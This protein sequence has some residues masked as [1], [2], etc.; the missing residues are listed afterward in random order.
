MPA[1]FDEA[2]EFLAAFDALVHLP[3]LAK[4]ELLLGLQETV[5]Q[6]G[7]VTDGEADYLAAVA[8]A[9]GAMGWN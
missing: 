5:A 3:P 1:P 9:I 7:R 2:T 4:R 8:D 6:D